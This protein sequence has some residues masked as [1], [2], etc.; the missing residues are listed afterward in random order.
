MPTRI[1]NPEIDAV[2]DASDGWRR[3]GKVITAGFR[4]DSFRTAFDFM[5]EVAQHAETRHQHLDWR[6]NDNH[7]QIDLTTHE[8]GGI[9][10]ID[11]DFSALISRIAN[12]IR[13]NQTTPDTAPGAQP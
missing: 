7:V 12:T 4:F 6:N 2:L 1:P 8:L 13:N 10:D 3:K 9:T 11:L 5:T